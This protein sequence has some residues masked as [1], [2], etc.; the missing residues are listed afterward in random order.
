V[1]LP[2]FCNSDR[3]SEISGY[4]P[5]E[6]AQLQKFF[7]IIKVHILSYF[8]KKNLRITPNIREAILMHTFVM[9]NPTNFF[10]IFIN[11]KKFAAKEK[12]LVKRK[13]L[14]KQFKTMPLY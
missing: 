12:T 9:K 13:I 6:V 3:F 4:T 14:F 2:H 10:K 8:H 11:A 7:F 5:P 1:I